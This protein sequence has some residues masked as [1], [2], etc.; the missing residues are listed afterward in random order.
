MANTGVEVVEGRVPAAC[1]AIRRRVFVEEQGVPPEADADGRDDACLHA[2]ARDRGAAV[3]CARLRPL[4]PGTAKVERV[5]VLA[6]RRKEGWGD[7]LMEA[8]E[9]ASRARGWNVLELHA[10]HTVVSFYERLGW[11][12]K[13]EPFEEAGIVH[14]AMVKTLS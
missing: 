6:E 2:L 13:G 10:Q 14:R 12:G 11:R 7:R 1:I 5:A 9:A 3:G 8:L 4:G